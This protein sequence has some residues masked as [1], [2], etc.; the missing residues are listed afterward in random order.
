MICPYVLLKALEENTQQI[1][2]MALGDLFKIMNVFNQPFFPCDTTT[3]MQNTK[4]FRAY[5]R[6]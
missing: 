4:Q 5:S 2:S 1:Y 3:E 6:N